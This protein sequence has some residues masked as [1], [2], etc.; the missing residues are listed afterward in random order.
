[1]YMYIFGNLSRNFSKSSFPAIVPVF[2]KKDV[3]MFS[4]LAW[5]VGTC[6]L[7]C[8]HPLESCRAELS[9]HHRI[10]QINRAGDGSANTSIQSQ[11]VFIGSENSPVVK[12]VGPVLLHSSDIKIY[13]ISS[14]GRYNFI[15]S[16]KGL[17]KD[18]LSLSVGMHGS[19]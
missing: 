16:H 2:P 14:H 18:I 9:D 1:M 3:A 6:W 8:C 5:Q 17:L 4:W 11:I 19:I 7:A 12:C 10:S 13:V 15:G